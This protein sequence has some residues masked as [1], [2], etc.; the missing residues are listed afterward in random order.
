MSKPN[1][2]I[3]V[4]MSLVKWFLVVLLVNNLIWAGV[5]YVILHGSEYSNTISLDDS[6]ENEITQGVTNG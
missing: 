6:F 5:L 2:F 4:F 1:P 3:E